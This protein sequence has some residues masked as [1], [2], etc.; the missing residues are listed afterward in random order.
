[1]KRAHV[2]LLLIAL[3]CQ[4]LAG[5]AP[6]ERERQ[7][8][9]LAQALQHGFMVEHHHH[10]HDHHHDD[11]ES[12]AAVHHES[13]E[14]DRV[15]HLHPSEGFQ[16]VSLAPEGRVLSVQHHRHPRAQAPDLLFRSAALPKWLRPPRGLSLA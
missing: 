1:M 5:W 7:V 15:A 9:A 14:A 16:T 10:D 11:D 13:A 6:S 3:L 12:G 4:A 2:F 8:Q